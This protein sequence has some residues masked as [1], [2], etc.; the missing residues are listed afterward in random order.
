VANK[1]GRRQDGAMVV[2]FTFLVLVVLG[3]MGLVVDLGQVQNR[4]AEIQGVAD[5]AA[6]AAARQ[7][8]GTAAGVNAA[9]V[10]AA[11]A[12]AGNHNYQ[13]GAAWPLADVR[14]AMR[15]SA[16]AGGAEDTWRTADE[17]VAAPAGMLFVRFD[18]ALI[19]PPDGAVA[20][21][22]M[23]LVSSSAV[24][25]TPSGRAVAGSS[26]IRVAPL[27]LCALNQTLPQPT[28]RDNN[29]GAP[30][31]MELV[32]Y[33]FRRGVG[34]DLLNLNPIGNTP[35]HFVV[36]PVDAPGQVGDAAN[37]A[38]AVVAPF[39]CS[40]TMLRPRVVGAGAEIAV[41]APFPIG[42]LF[43]QLNSRFGIYGAGPL[44]CDPFGAPRDRNVT[45]Y[46]GTGTN[47][48]PATTSQTA[49]Q[50]VIG[51]NLMTVAELPSPAPAPGNVQATDYGRLWAYA[52]PVRW[53]T[54]LATPT[55]PAAGYASF[56]KAEHS[57]LYPVA[58]GGPLLGAAYSAGTPTW[59]PYAA[60]TSASTDP[61]L[62]LR[63]VL[64]VPLLACPVPANGLAQVLA[65]GRFFMT[66][67]ATATAISAEFAGLAPES[68]L[69]GPVELY[70]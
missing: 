41:A 66:V 1:P 44:A 6:L 68:S 63:R 43:E 2:M 13:P 28:F 26:S 14:D 11:A 51:G 45:S 7:L 32:E 64:N 24:A 60:A 9:V 49:A 58:S 18:S 25:V 61:R 29:N 42:A 10:A 34:Y 35:L 21:V 5:A 27:A 65:V 53:S 3:F 62:R 70:R 38:A 12:T 19:T 16:Q 57:I 22:F 31:G 37:L 15:F 69:R 4:H 47:F 46:N 30:A 56:P 40:G 33:G 8:N 20:P 55:E 54:Y 17:A 50:S 23:R 52:R 59:T 67:P 36:N 48:W 39:A